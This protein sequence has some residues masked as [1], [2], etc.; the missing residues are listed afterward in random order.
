MA[1]NIA[2]VSY[3]PFIPT[4]GGIQR[5]TDILCRMLQTRGYQVYYFNVKK[6]STEYDFPAPVVFCETTDVGDTRNGELYRNF[7][8]ENKIDII[9][10]QDGQ[11]FTTRLFHDPQYVPESV[12]TIAF[13][14]SVPT[15]ECNH[16]GRWLWLRLRYGGSGW[17]ERLKDLVRLIL[18]PRTKKRHLGVFLSTYSFLRESGTR[19]CFLSP[20]FIEEARNTGLDLPEPLLSIPNPN[21]YNESDLPETFCKQKEILYVGRMENEVKQVSLLLDIWKRVS[22]AAPDWK[23]ILL[24]EGKNLESLQK[25]AARLRLHNVEFTGRQ[26]PRPY[27]ERASILC[28]TSLFEGFGMVLTEAQQF[29]VVPIAFDSFASVHS[30]ITPGENGELVQAFSTKEYGQKLLHLMQDSSYRERLAAKGR[31]TVRQFAPERIADMW[32]ELLHSL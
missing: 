12:K 5:V 2:I 30:I 32:D 25:K 14:H 17:K 31:E 24:G 8:E 27:Y 18:Y 13:I 20:Y 10:D 3:D 23:L 9:I 16:L 6:T 22:A 29:G 7:L 11:F 1:K 19:V 28:M 26:D 21:T 4:Q 15:Q